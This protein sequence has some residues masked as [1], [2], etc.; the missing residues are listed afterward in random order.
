LAVPGLA[1]GGTYD[2]ILAQNTKSVSLDAKPTNLSA[3]KVKLADKPQ[4]KP[5][6]EPKK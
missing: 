3:L 1:P 2:V 5:Q 4:P 6:P